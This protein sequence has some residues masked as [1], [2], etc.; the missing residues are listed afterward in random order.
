M[1]NK[2]IVLQINIKGLDRLNELLK[3][4]EDLEL[5]VEVN[6]GKED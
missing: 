6:Q 2:K 5:E 3:E 4:I 1:E